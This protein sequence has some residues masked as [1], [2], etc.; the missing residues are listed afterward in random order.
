MYE[1]PYLDVESDLLENEIWKALP[2]YVGYY[3]VSNQGRVRSMDRII[4]HPRLKEQFVKG[5][6]LKQKVNINFNTVN[7][8]KMVDLQVALSKEGRTSFRNVR[9][10]VYLTF[11]DSSLNYSQDKKIIINKDCDGFNNRIDNIKAVN[12]SMK[13][14]RALERNRVPKSH[15]STAD[16]SS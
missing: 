12:L 16:R 7:K 6:I 9:R 1:Y 2:D 10:L 3:E 11:I 5:K 14:I 13:S 15:L 8:E 4:P